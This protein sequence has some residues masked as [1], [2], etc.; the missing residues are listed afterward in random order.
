MS[1]SFEIGMDSAASGGSYIHLPNGAGDFW[2][3]PN[4]RQKAEYCFNVPNA[5]TYRIDGKVYGADNL[6]DSFYVKVEGAPDK[7]YLWDVLPNT[8]YL[9]DS[10]NDRNQFLDLVTFP[11]QRTT[12]CHRLCS[13]RWHPAGHNQLV[14]TVPGAQVVH[15][16]SWRRCSGDNQPEMSGMSEKFDFSTISL[17]LMDAETRGENFKQK[18]QADRFGQV[19][20]DGMTP[21]DYLLQFS[22]TDGM[23]LSSAPLLH[24]RVWNRACQFVSLLRLTNELNSRSMSVPSQHRMTSPTDLPLITASHEIAKQGAQ[25]CAPCFSS[26]IFPIPTAL[27]SSFP[28]AQ[29]CRTQWYGILCKKSHVQL[30]SV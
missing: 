12:H 28:S 9:L 26:P 11:L 19:H 29:N 20:F 10:V 30:S 15:Q 3:G 22:S 27:S 24:N 23:S 16:S 5:G 4:A 6:S 7:G 21:G 13:R 25:C 17:V 2:N 14:E 8:S 18:Q 1:G